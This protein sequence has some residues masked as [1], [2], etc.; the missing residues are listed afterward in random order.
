MK[1]SVVVI[2]A[3]IAGLTAAYRLNKLVKSAG[4]AVDVTVLEKEGRL[5]GTIQTEYADGFVIEAGPDCFFAEK[6]HAGMLVNELGMADRLIGTNDENQGTYVLWH[7]RLHKLPEGVI[8]M[9]PTKFTPFATSTLFSIPG[10]IRM[11]M[12]MFVPR[13]ADGVDESL[14]EFT[15]RRFGR[16]ALDRIAEPLIAGVHAGDPGTM[17]VKSSFPRFV[18]MEAR[19][20][21][22][23]KG[24][25]KARSAMR[26]Q[27]AGKVGK[28]TTMFMTMKNG[29]KELIDA[30]VRQSGGVS[31]RTG[32]G[33][34]SVERAVND[35]VDGTSA[36]RVVLSNGEDVKADGVIIAVP[37]YAAAGMVSPLSGELSQLLMSIPYVSTATVSLAY[38]KKDVRMPLKGF[39]VVIPAKEKRNIMAATWTSSKF[40]HR[41]PEGAVLL[42]CFVGG[43]KNQDMVFKTDDEILGLIRADLGD[44]M[45]IAAGPKLARI[46]RWERAMPQY[47]IGHESRLKAIEQLVADAGNLH[48]CGS[49]YRGIGISDSINSGNVAAQ[50]ALK[51]LL[52]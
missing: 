12:E 18:D 36:F 45:G 15:V 9:I 7:G 11:G 48:I 47:T 34:K 19:Y 46:Y 32:T 29:L 30:I 41:A 6:P 22:L 3:G 23:I 25:I 33:V 43:A 37:A 21:S 1:R 24:M 38:D 20:G 2:G 26:R 31:F 16:E 8:L 40:A 5:G 13:R 28:G 50:Q 52:E 14:A 42:R 10:K 39:G 51:H 35:G 17:S 44:I 49:A 4:I 27:V